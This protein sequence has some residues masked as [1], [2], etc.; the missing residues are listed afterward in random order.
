[1]R[2]LFI[3]MAT[4]MAIPS[5]SQKSHLVGVK[6]GLNLSRFLS[7]NN[8]ESS[9]KPGF[10]V[11]VYLKAPVTKNI[12]IRPEAFYSCQGQ[13]LNSISDVSGTSTRQSIHANYLNAPVLMEFGK[14]LTIQIGPQMSYLLTANKV[15]I[16]EDETTKEDI[17]SSMKNFD[18]SAVAGIGINPHP[19]FNAG[20][21]INY[22]LTNIFSDK[23][24]NERTSNHVF[25]VY[26]GY[27]F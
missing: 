12:F 17:K 11:G 8:Q 26:V 5:F 16:T 6:A 15:I 7:E 19:C 13:R 27:T 22:G 10:H 14:K 9:F 2:T 23:A 18:L 3:C 20:M 21:R 24:I 25:H 4:L 1:M